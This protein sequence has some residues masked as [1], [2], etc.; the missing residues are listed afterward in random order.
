MIVEFNYLDVLNNSIIHL[1]QREIDNIP[2]VGTYIE[3]DQDVYQIDSV[4]HPTSVVGYP[5]DI[6]CLTIISV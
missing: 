2:Q 6:C 5:V 3:I 1:G 4:F